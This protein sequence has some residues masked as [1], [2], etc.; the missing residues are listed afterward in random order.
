MRWGCWSFWSGGRVRFR[1]VGFGFGG[2]RLAVAV[3]ATGFHGG[4]GLWVLHERLPDEGGAE[5][6]CH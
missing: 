2:A 6:F 3:E 1:G 4:D 5:I